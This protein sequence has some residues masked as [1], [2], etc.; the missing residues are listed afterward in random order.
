MFSPNY[1]STI[2]LY[3]YIIARRVR[4]ILMNQNRGR[5]LDIRS[6]HL[7]FATSL[8]SQSPNFVATTCI[9]QCLQQFEAHEY[10]LWQRAGQPQF[11]DNDLLY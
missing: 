2:L 5:R 3:Q 6:Q 4:V 10:M 11:Q 7:W 9:T 1:R 8:F